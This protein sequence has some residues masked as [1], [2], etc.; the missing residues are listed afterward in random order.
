MRVPYLL[1]FF[2]L[3][4]IASTNA[5]SVTAV[6][7]S[8][9]DSLY[10]QNFDGLP[11]SGSF[12]L[13]GKGPHNLSGIPINGTN[14]I[15]WQF[16]AYAGSTTN[17][18]FGP[19]TGSATGHGVYSLGTS[20]STDRALG[21]LA[22]S[23]GIYGFGILL[24]NNT[25]GNINS[26]AIAFTA[27]Q[28]RKGGSTNK[29][30]WKCYY[31]T[32]AI[33]S[34][35]QTNKM[36]ASTLGFSSIQNTSGS[37]TLNGNLAENKQFI[38]GTITGID[39]KPGEQILLMW[40][41]ADETGSD[42]IVAI[43][44]FSLKGSF[45][46]TNNNTVQQII[47]IATNPTNAD[48]IQYQVSLSGNTTGLTKNNFSLITN[49]ITNAS[50][51]K[52]E[53]S[54][55]YYTASVY[56]GTGTGYI[57][58]G[59]ANSTNLIPGLSNIPFYSIDTQWI[60][61]VK[62]IQ[63]S[64]THGPDTLLQLNDTLQLLLQFNE[65]VFLDTVN[66]F[67][68]IP[69]TIGSKVKNI[70]FVSGNG[71]TTLAFHYLVQPGETDKDG[72]RIAS[73]F[74]A[75]NLSIK[76]ESGNLASLTISSAAIQ[77]IRIDAI[78]PEFTQPADT[79]IHFCNNSGSI[80]LDPFLKINNKEMNE[81]LQ[82]K[83]V[84]APVYYTINKLI[85][86]S[87]ASTTTLLPN[88]F[89]INNPSQSNLTDTCLFS[90]S[91]GINT[92]YKKIIFSLSNSYTWTGT[93]NSLWT[94]PANWCNNALPPD[95]A[96]I[97]IPATAV[98]MPLIN[99]TVSVNQITISE[100]ASLNVTGILKLRNNITAADT[101]LDLRNGSLVMQGDLMQTIDGRYLKESVIQ[102][103]VIA[104]NNGASINGLVKITHSLTLEKGLF[105]T[106]NKLIFTN[107]TILS[108]ISNNVGM[109]GKIMLET[110]W[111]GK[112]TGRYLVGNP[113][114]NVLK[115][116]DFASSFLLQKIKLSES[117]VDTAA[118]EELAKFNAGWSILSPSNQYQKDTISGYPNLG[119]QQIPIFQIDSS[120]FAVASNPY[121]SPI[122]IQ[123]I[124]PG[125]GLAKY[126]WIWNPKQ[127]KQGGF[128]CIASDQS[129][130][131][132]TG[133]ALVIY[134]FVPTSSTLMV[135]EEAKTNTWRTSNNATIEKNNTYMFS[136]DLWQDNSFQDRLTFIHAD[137]GRSNFDSSDAPKLFQSGYN[138]FSKSSDG[139]SLAVDTRKID[140]NTIIPI[141]M[142]NLGIGS[143]QLRIGN[144][145]L[146]VDNKLVIHDR[147]LNKF[148]V[149]QKDS[150]Y[151]FYVSTDS[152]SR[153]EGR[154]E[155]A[156][157]IPLATPEQLTHT[158]VVKLYPN[159]VQQ[160]LTVHV[161]TNTNEPTQIRIIN[162]NGVVIKT[163]APFLERKAL[164]KIPVSD[165]PNGVY[166]L[167]ISSGDTNQS[168]QFFKQ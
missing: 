25:G 130:I 106:N 94:N 24:T 91:D 128:T 100:K 119:T 39:W 116:S 82:W 84:K 131:L 47:P 74:N 97:L 120:G 98:N 152:M 126:Y 114:E 66:G 5:Q 117:K 62:P 95:S 17:A 76:D 93:V 3:L 140:N 50:I 102:K 85:F 51:T 35:D 107:Q 52:I 40:E 34:I 159:P 103:L 137:N 129:Y 166:I 30:F 146:P 58:L 108:P 46:Q 33:S 64:F 86:D 71:T 67:S 150:S 123:Y 96:N 87:S 142:S 57:S 60:D 153:K 154:F 165:V 69:V 11:L 55:K 109:Q 13:S 124:Q 138:V 125:N 163:I 148:L 127:G 147:Y 65:P 75:K 132:N 158:L 36:E 155:I 141:N 113:F 79:I 160:E 88:G 139:K 149:L 115:R 44:D 70:S 145:A 167:Q 10:T 143:Y 43:D 168:L 162:T 89:I 118:F 121:L 81:P 19:S 41:D 59:I 12:S 56:T 78:S 28:W 133:E 151:T 20:S 164:I 104:N 6:S 90:I 16:L 156:A 134:S 9:R 92:A 144:V 14:I 135:T 15:G 45:I 21:S 8:V 61:K 48:T 101:S 80:N 112:D 4:A 18:F 23:T 111:L 99:T 63:Q 77:K 37:A 31:K 72:I 42:D 54:G 38:N 7:Y 68:Y 27:E 110:G 2:I 157:N 29:N 105:N 26:V 122:N 161:S 49:G 53:G 136:I 1:C 32:G 83:L 73:A 22:S